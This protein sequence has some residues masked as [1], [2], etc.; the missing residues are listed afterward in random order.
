MRW[1]FRVYFSLPFL[2]LSGQSFTFSGDRMS[3][4]QR[5]GETVLEGKAEVRWDNLKL[6]ADRITIVGN[7]AKVVRAI[8]SVVFYDSENRTTLRSTQLRYDQRTK[9][10]QAVGNVAADRPKDNLK[11]RSEFLRYDEKNKLWEFESQVVFVGEDFTGRAE[12]IRYNES[13]FLL[14]LEGDAQLTRDNESFQAQF[15]TIHTQNRDL[16]MKG[17]IT[18]TIKENP[19]GG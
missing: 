7:E 19:N 4:N 9:I 11:I 15:I 2:F 10:V 3:F 8:G 16:Q 1:L 12:R 6:T 13:T 5:T 14:E 17:G 18:G